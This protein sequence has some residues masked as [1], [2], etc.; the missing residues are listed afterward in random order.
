MIKN[1]VNIVRPLLGKE[2]VIEV[3][4]KSSMDTPFEFKRI[5]THN[6]NESRLIT[7]EVVMLN[8]TSYIM[9]YKPSD[10]THYGFV[11]SAYNPFHKI[12]VVYVNNSYGQLEKVLVLNNLYET[13]LWFDRINN[14]VLH[15]VNNNTFDVDINKRRNMN[16][17]NT[18]NKDNYS[19]FIKPSDILCRQDYFD[20]NNF[21][22]FFIDRNNMTDFKSFYNKEMLS[23]VDYINGINHKELDIE[24]KISKASVMINSISQRYLC[25]DSVL[26]TECLKFRKMIKTTSMNKILNKELNGYIQ[27]L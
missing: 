18:K 19:Y 23:S 22:I 9:N 24:T 8:F 20:T 21:N 7:N 3:S 2:I 4:K 1:E 25:R 15:A 26:V 14:M 12:G 27:S 16:S 6:F 11:F 17:S 10:D 13:I 5:D